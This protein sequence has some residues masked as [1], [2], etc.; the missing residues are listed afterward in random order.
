ML[1]LETLAAF[2]RRYP[3]TLFIDFM[4]YVI[5]AGG[6]YLIV[7]LALSSA[8]SGRKIRSETPVRKQILREIAASLRTVLIFAAFGTLIGLGASAGVV[9]LYFD[10]A[11]YGWGWLIAS[12]VILILA[13]DA[14]FYWTHWLM[15]RVRPLR[16]IHRLHHRSHNPTPFTSYAF[17]WPE[18]AL[19]AVFFP[20]ILLI[21]PAHPVA[22]LAFTSHMMIRNAIGHCGYEVF[23]A[24][25]SGNPLVGWMTTVTHHDLHHADARWNLGLYFTWWDRW[26][27]TEHPDYAAHFKRAIGAPAP[28]PAG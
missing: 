16:R 8:L 10:I 27:G 20:L 1:C 3:D 28:S 22:L 7:N 17:D 12:T 11:A 4:R 24:G 5:G 6:V 23:P 14:W 19:N 25:R 26:M 2:A 18:A 13:H 21:V 9:P 15:H